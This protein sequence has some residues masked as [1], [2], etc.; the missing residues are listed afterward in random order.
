MYIKPWA[1]TTDAKKNKKALPWIRALHVWETECTAMTSQQ[2]RQGYQAWECLRVFRNGISS[3]GGPGTREVCVEGRV[4]KM[5]LGGENK[6]SINQT[7][8][9]RTFQSER[10]ITKLLN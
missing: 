2:H 4:F 7:T 5:R 9:G 3:P 10:A 1:S 6:I 8:R